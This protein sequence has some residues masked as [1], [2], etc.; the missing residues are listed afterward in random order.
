MLPNL[1][2]N[3]V[4]GMITRKDL[5]N[6]KD[7]HTRR[8]LRRNQADADLIRYILPDEFNGD[9]VDTVGPSEINSPT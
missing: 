3:E 5:T 9:M 1:R 7:H 4:V 8:Y 2:Y 6:V